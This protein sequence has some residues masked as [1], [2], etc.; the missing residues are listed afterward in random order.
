MRQNITEEQKIHEEWFKQAEEVKLDTLPKFLDHLINDYV[1]DYGTIVHAIAAGAIATAWAMNA[2]EQGGITG[3]QASCLTWSFI[4]HWYYNNNKTGMRL[5]DY[6]KMLYPQY[7][8][9]FA[10]TIS[11]GTWEALQ[12]EAK[13]NLES[14]EQAHAD[15]AQH[16]QSIVDGVVPFGYTVKDD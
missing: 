7:E 15:V 9:R 12:K 5:I 1:H 6:D 14:H 10:K 16:W 8:D 11:K 4:R 13:A 3:F 2:S